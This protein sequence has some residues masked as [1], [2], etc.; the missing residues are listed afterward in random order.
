[1]ANDWP[2]AAVRTG[3]ATWRKALKP[4]MCLWRRAA[5]RNDYSPNAAVFTHS[6]HELTGET[7]IDQSG[8]ESRD[9]SDRETGFGFHQP[10]FDAVAA[11]ISGIAPAV[12]HTATA[13]VV[14]ATIIVCFP[15][16]PAPKG[17]QTLGVLS[18][19]QTHV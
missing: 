2:P 13:V 4:S 10:A 17:R 18:P 7:F 8:R 12:S 16:R 15:E 6:I 11:A 19:L 1:M 3:R 5:R 9:E 14:T